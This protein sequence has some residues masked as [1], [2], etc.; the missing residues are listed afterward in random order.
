M[1]PAD[2]VTDPVCSAG[3]PWAECTWRGEDRRSTTVP[4]TITLSNCILLD[5]DPPRARRGGL[6]VEE[7]VI[8]AAGETVVPRVGDEVH[9]CGGAVVLPG[10]VNGHT[11]LYS[12]L[13]VGMPPPEQS[14]EN[15]LQILERVWWKLDMALDETAIRA[16]ATI[17]ALEALR[18]GTTTLIDHH[19]SPNCVAGS[20]DVIEQSLE[21]VGLRGVLCYE[22]TDRHG[23]AG[24]DAGLAENTRYLEQC[25]NRCEGRFAALVG[26]HALF[27]LEDETLT[28]L[29][30]LMRH[31]EVGLHIHIAEDP[32]DEDACTAQHQT[33]LLQRLQSYGLLQPE[34]LFAHATH[35]PEDELAA[36]ARTGC[37]VA[38]NTRSNMNNSVGYAP[39]QLMFGRIP[40]ALGTDGI[41]GNM[42]A[43]ARAAYFKLRD[44]TTDLGP[45]AVPPMLA[46]SARRASES[47]HI[48]MGK[49]EP[50]QAADIV[51]T[52]YVPATPIDDGN[53]AG[54]LLFGVEARHV[55]DVMIGGQWRL[56]D[57]AV[58]GVDER[59]ERAAAVPVA[60][61]L[62]DRM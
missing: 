25:T 36:F 46:Q 8:V 35:L 19:A 43:E 37:T 61:R 21:A 33:F 31:Y 27:T 4:E 50:G 55:K 29:R 22:T 32:C 48:E 2:T 14:P 58:L 44:E 47:L 7:G 53:V 3:W 23:P 5:L 12:A 6:R 15:F 57:R 20:L 60:A 9:N 49:L 13:A 34:S 24:R 30:D 45:D 39:M 10:L 18:C 52:D 62:W 51:V 38:H 28:E 11:H 59:A 16:S 1:Q 56:R 17:G 26:A 54:H 42:L 41:G 40:V